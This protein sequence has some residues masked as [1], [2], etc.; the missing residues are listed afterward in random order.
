MQ[1][2]ICSSLL[3]TRPNLCIIPT[4]TLISSPPLTKTSTSPPAATVLSFSSTPALLHNKRQLSLICLLCIICRRALVHFSPF[5]VIVVMLYTALPLK[6]I[7]G[8]LRQARVVFTSVINTWDY[9]SVPFKF[10][11]TIAAVLSEDC[12]VLFFLWGFREAE[13]VGKGNH[14]SSESA[15][16]CNA[17]NT[18]Q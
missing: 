14:S 16:I 11:A 8:D 9:A 18:F 6:R 1:L 17:A 4:N 13:G 12:T 5:L 2:M 10:P 7:R 3:F 15:N